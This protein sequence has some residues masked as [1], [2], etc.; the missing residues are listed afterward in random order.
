MHAAFRE[1]VARRR[2]LT[3]VVLALASPV[4]AMQGPVTMMIAEAVQ[5]DG[6]A[7]TVAIASLETSIAALKGRRLEVPVLGIPRGSLLDT[8]DDRRGRQSHEAIDIAA[9][10]GTPVVAVDDGRIVK[11][12]QSAAG[13]LTIYQFDRDQQFSY[14]Y[15]HLDRYAEGVREGAP[16]KRGDLIGYVGSTGNASPDAPHLHFAIF[17]LDPDLKWWK[18]TALNPFPILTDATK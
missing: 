17:K 15:A 2:L 14:Y 3:L 9:P 16:V 5:A 10:R 12:F 6:A 13:G 8:Y 11:L 1:A 7:R 4:V 18:G